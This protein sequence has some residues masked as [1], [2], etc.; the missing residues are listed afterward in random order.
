MEN[1]WR[2]NDGVGVIRR[3]RLCLC[4]F[5]PNPP[6]RGPFFAP[7]TLK[8]D[9][10]IA[11]ILDHDFLM[12]SVMPFPVFPPQNS[13][14][15]RFRPQR[16]WSPVINLNRSPR[17]YCLSRMSTTAVEF[18][19]SLS[20][21][22]KQ[23]E[24]LTLDTALMPPMNC[25]FSWRKWERVSGLAVVLRS[26][27]NLKVSECYGYLTPPQRETK[28]TMKLSF[29]SA[30][31]PATRT[32]RRVGTSTRSSAQMPHPSPRSKDL[33]LDSHH[34][35][36]SESMTEFGCALLYQKRKR[37]TQDPSKKLT[38]PIYPAND[39]E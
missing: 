26:R 25:I 35:Q 36:T 6:L 1:R 20:F 11:P 29:T 27:S 12:W 31:A 28:N 21:R 3:C 37:L 19:A 30:V 7:I 14:L 32:L 4:G 38:A 18:N 34:L 2:G 39:C 9:F 23:K 10:H 16:L 5:I 13:F 33:V 22:L 15:P 24:R 8:I 17:R